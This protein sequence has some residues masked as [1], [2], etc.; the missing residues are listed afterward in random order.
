MA[1][2]GL[3]TESVV[4]AAARQ[5][6]E[7]GLD[8]VTLAGLASSLGV[9]PPSLY[10]HVAGLEDL[11]T[12]IAA[13]G[14]EQLAAALQ[15]AA[16]GLAGSEALSAVAAAYRAYALA[17]PGSYEAL[18]RVIPRGEDFVEAAGRVVAVVLA[19]LLGYGLEGEEAL[20]ATR[21][22][23]S[24]LHGFV[25]LETQQGF[26]LP[27]DLDESFAAL[28]AMLDRGLRGEPTPRRRPGA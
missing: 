13:R 7:Q 28:V 24:A 8:A 12:R 4:A 19:V 21:A 2:A 1:R 25:L 9:R 11:R 20:H 15:Q 16:A 22:I 17:H 10:A 6:D 18:Q 14:A 27:L 3:T 26:G 5:A 23:R